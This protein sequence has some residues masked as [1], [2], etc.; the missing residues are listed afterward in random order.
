MLEVVLLVVVAAVSWASDLEAVVAALRSVVDALRVAAVAAAP[1]RAVVRASGALV[2][3]VVVAIVLVALALVP[4]PVLRCMHRALVRVGRALVAVVVV[5]VAQVFHAL[6]GRHQGHHRHRLLHLLVFLVRLVLLVVGDTGGVRHRFV[7]LTVEHVGPRLA[8][9]SEE[10]QRP[11]PLGVR[12]H[13][14]DEDALVLCRDV[15]RLRRQGIGLVLA[16]V[17]VPHLALDAGGPFRDVHHF[18]GAT[19]QDLDLAVV[20]HKAHRVWLHQDALLGSAQAE[21]LGEERS[22]AMVSIRDVPEVDDGFL[23]ALFLPVVDRQDLLGVVHQQ[24]IVLARH[25]DHAEALVQALVRRPHDRRHDAQAPLHERRELLR[26]IVLRLDLGVAVGCEVGLGVAGGESARVVGEVACRALVHV[27]LRHLEL[28]KA[29]L[30]HRPLELVVLVDVDDVEDGDHDDA[31]LVVLGEV[32]DGG[33]VAHV[34]LLHF[35]GDVLVGQHVL[36]AP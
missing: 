8:V 11:V 7:Q 17:R 34:Q 25:R 33:N 9:A 2:T 13:L 27:V 29:D 32:L 28:L 4:R 22:G 5:V 1:L 16:L 24:E 18:F 10:L 30:G 14:G 21:M 23:D 31:V 35:V 26:C 15:A 19:H 20:G 3:L 12:V 6:V 36:E